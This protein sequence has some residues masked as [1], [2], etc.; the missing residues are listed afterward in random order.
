MML[1]RFSLVEP[2]GLTTHIRGH[3]S[4]LLPETIT[5]VQTPEAA[6]PQ[7]P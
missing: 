2:Q 4:I 3:M 5:R 7:R 1:E 6:G